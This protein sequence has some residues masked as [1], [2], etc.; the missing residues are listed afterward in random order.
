MMLLSCKSQWQIPSDQ[1]CN[2]AFSM[3]TNSIAESL[4]TIEKGW[5]DGKGS[6]VSTSDKDIFIACMSGT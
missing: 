2:T 4:K 3:A 6:P 5:F 1:S